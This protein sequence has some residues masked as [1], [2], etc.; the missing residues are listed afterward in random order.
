MVEV[1][2]GDLDTLE[3]GRDRIMGCMTGDRSGCLAIL[4][5]R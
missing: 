1:E 5:R 3:R 4:R 2:T